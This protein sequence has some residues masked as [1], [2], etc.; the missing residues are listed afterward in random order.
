MCCC[1]TGFPCQSNTLFRLSNL[2]VGVETK[3]CTTVVHTIKE[4]IDLSSKCLWKGNA[5]QCQ[6]DMSWSRNLVARAFPVLLHGLQW[7][8]SCIKAKYLRT[9]CID[10]KS[11]F[12]RARSKTGS[13][14]CPLLYTCTAN[15]R[16]SW[17]YAKPLPPEGWG[18]SATRVCRAG[19]WSGP[20]TWV[21]MR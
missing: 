21:N 2:W 20:V 1:A 9:V 5:V 14:I 16:K 13:S 12:A 8:C 19:L 3:E 17:E 10:G 11:L 15:D 18:S 4:G 7:P 6:K